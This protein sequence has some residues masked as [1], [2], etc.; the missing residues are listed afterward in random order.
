MAS[1]TETIEPKQPSGAN[2]GSFPDEWWSGSLDAATI[3]KTQ[4]E[5][6]VAVHDARKTAAEADIAE[7]EA[8]RA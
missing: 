7:I 2:A 3:P 5:T 4:A 6:I 8:A 1:T